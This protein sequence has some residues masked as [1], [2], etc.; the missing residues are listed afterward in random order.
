M[1][2]A[3]LLDTAKPSAPRHSGR[4]H[5]IFETIVALLALILIITGFSLYVSQ[6]FTHETH[7]GG[8]QI[9]GHT[10]EPAYSLAEM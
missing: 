7:V 2:S 3:T 4:E 1:L 6:S 10:Q 9:V 5:V 8:A